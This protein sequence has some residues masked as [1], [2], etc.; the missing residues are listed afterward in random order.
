MWNLFKSQTITLSLKVYPCEF[1]NETFD[2]YR[3]EVGLKINIQ[4]EKRGEYT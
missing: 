4:R 2:S 1:I 3:V